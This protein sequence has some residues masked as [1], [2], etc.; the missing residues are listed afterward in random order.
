MHY[1]QIK[2]NKREKI[3]SEMISRGY[4]V[5]V[6]MILDRSQNKKTQ[7]EIDFVVNNGDKRVYIQSAYQIDNNEK[8]ISETKSLREIKNSD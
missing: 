1:H 4:S 5:D 6:G 2:G 7:L 3:Y 8:L